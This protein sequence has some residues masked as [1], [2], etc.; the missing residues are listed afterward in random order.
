MWLGIMVWLLISR[1]RSCEH[2]V[3]CLRNVRGRSLLL[4]WHQRLQLKRHAHTYRK[5]EK[6][7]QTNIQHGDSL[8]KFSPNEIS[9]N[10][11]LWEQHEITQRRKNLHILS[12]PLHHS[13][14]LSKARH[15]Y[16]RVFHVSEINPLQTL[17][18]EWW[19]P[20]RKKK[21]GSCSGL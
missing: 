15:L 17:C 7:V 10:F 2:V 13:S 11:N 21:K 18:G 6:H 3:A 12:I 19:L 16:L 4:T 8:I 20:W 1:S 9:S 5:R 14:P